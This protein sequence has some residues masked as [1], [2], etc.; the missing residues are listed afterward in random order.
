[1]E[2]EAQRFNPKKWVGLLGSHLS[3]SNNFFLKLPFSYIYSKLECYPN[4][5]FY[6]TSYFWSP[7]NS[8]QTAW[9]GA[10]QIKIPNSKT[11]PRIINAS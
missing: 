4:K 10:V 8:I 11:E 5:E 7:R 2:L 6:I 9:S 1:M 3:I